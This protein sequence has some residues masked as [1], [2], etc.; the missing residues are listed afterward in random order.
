VRGIFALI[1]LCWKV[2]DKN[3]LKNCKKFDEEK[4]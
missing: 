2:D 3:I 1:S 4:N